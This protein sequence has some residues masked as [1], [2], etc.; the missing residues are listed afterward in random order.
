MKGKMLADIK[1]RY[2]GKPFTALLEKSTFL[3]PRYKTDYMDD[4]KVEEKNMD[5]REVLLNKDKNFGVPDLLTTGPSSVKNDLVSSHPLE[6][7][8]KN[9]N[10]GPSLTSSNALYDALTGNDE[11]IGFED[12]LNAPEDQEVVGQPHALQERLD[13]LL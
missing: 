6:K 13:G 9:I 7:S 10:R 1:E 3:D 2:E 12:F 5:N 4:E 8:E 11:D